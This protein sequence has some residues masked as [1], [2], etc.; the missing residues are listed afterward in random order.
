MKVLAIN[1]SP[2]KDRNTATLLKNALEGAS[3]QG[4]ETELIHIYDQNFKGCTSCLACRLK[5]GKSYS[6]CAQRDGLTPLLEK[7]LE[8]DVLILGSPVYFNSLTGEMRSFYER[9]AYPYMPI[10]SQS[11]SRFPKK[12]NVGLILTITANDA[13]IKNMGINRHFEITEQTMGFVFG[14]AESIIA[15]DIS[16]YKD[17]TK[18]AGSHEGMA[19]AMQRS[20]ENMVIY[21]KKAF[22]MGVRLLSKNV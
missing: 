17:Y 8:I 1:G 16:L 22:D 9:A 13:L 4:A 20:T 2:R 3:S 15:S 7:L 10:D 12:I 6:K 18:Y 11:G 19:E 14:S 21:G 5:D